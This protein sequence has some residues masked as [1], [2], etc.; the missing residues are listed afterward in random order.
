MKELIQML[1][2]RIKFRELNFF[3]SYPFSFSFFRCITNFKMAL[4]LRF[5]IHK[6]AETGGEGILPAPPVAV[7]THCV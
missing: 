7:S 6:S 5:G 2:I 1:P 3:A 4:S